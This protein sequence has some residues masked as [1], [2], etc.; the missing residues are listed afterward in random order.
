V[1]SAT[2]VSKVHTK[3]S[4]ISDLILPICYFRPFSLVPSYDHVVIVLIYLMFPIAFV[5]NGRAYFLGLAVSLFY[6]GYM[7]LID[8][9]ST[10]DKVWEL[11]AYGAYLFFLNMLCMFLSRF[12]EY[13]MRSGILSRYQVVYQNLVFQVS[14]SKFLCASYLITIS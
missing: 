7:A 12:Q 8:K 14:K 2:L 5:K 3:I 1:I 9:I 4:S 11:T 10:L 6:F 13:N